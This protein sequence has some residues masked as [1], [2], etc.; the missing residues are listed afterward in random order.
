MKS[1]YQRIARSMRVASLPLIL[2]AAGFCSQS[3][4]AGSNG[5]GAPSGATVAGTSSVP[6]PGQSAQ[7][8]LLLNSSAP[9]FTNGVTPPNSQYLPGTSVRFTTNTLQYQ[10]SAVN[11]VYTPGTSQTLQ[12]PGGNLYTINDQGG[13]FIILTQFLAAI[14]N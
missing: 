1:P 4:F 13:S 10:L 2:L 6:T 7:T 14:A 3:A 8:G 11:I 12:G 5:S 9:V